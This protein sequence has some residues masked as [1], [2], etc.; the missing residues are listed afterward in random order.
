M[1]DWRTTEEGLIIV[2][3][4][5]GDEF[6]PT[7]TGK[8]AETMRAGMERWTETVQK[9]ADKFG[10]PVRWPMAMVYQ[11]SSFYPRAFRQERQPDGTPI[12]LMGRLLTG[13]GLLQITHPTLKMG[14]TDEELYDPELNLS[15]GC[16]YMAHLAEKPEVNRDFPKLSA[17]YNAGSVRKSDKNEW[18]MVCYGSH[19]DSEVSAQNFFVLENMSDVD[20]AAKFAVAQQFDLL[21]IARETYEA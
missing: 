9:V 7:L 3:K 2:T 14:H 15:I 21:T 18:G 20:K 12:M 13:I 6:I 19:I 17:C 1:Y 5:S 8:Y 11:E 16:R 4:E 10:L